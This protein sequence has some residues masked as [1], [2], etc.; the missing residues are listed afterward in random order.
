MAG[1]TSNNVICE[2]LVGGGGA[3]LTIY[4]GLS[5][6][7]EVDSRLSLSQQ[8]VLGADATVAAATR[9]A[10]HGTHD[11]D[12]HLQFPALLPFKETVLATTVYFGVNCRHG[13]NLF[14]LV[15]DRLR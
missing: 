5:D 10:G 7:H 6:N 14:V 12:L 1:L 13:P 15:H 11:S 9:S 4:G 2:Q 3:R 8:R